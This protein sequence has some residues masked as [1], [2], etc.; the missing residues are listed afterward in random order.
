MAEVRDIVGCL[1]QRDRRT[2]IKVAR[3]CP[4]AAVLVDAELAEHVVEAVIL[5]HDHNDM[6]NR[7]HRRHR[8]GLHDARLRSR[9]DRDETPSN[10]EHQRCAAEG[11]RTPGH[12]GDQ[13]HK[14]MGMIEL[15]STDPPQT[16]A[17]KIPQDVAPWTPHA[18]RCPESHSDRGYALKPSDCPD[19]RSLC[20]EADGQFGAS[21]A[22]PYG[23]A[24]PGT[25]Q[26]VAL[27]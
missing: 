21:P 12:G 18:L 8:R 20:D 24:W 14:P 22:R 6:L 13:S 3:Q 15:R 23:L 10:D 19:A 11:C 1:M 9:P 26:T 4:V 17:G 27:N 16:V 5:F 7:R 25:G 2:T